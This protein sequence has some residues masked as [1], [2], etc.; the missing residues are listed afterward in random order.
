MKNGKRIITRSIQLDE[1]LDNALDAKA[2]ALNISR[3]AYMRAVL[4]Q[5]AEGAVTVD[6]QTVAMREGHSNGTRTR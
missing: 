2:K 4:A 1:S 5:A 6:P 3:A